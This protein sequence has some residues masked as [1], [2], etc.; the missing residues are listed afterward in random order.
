MQGKR[1]GILKKLGIKA[2]K[3]IAGRFP[4][5]RVR[6]WGLRL[7]GF[8]VGRKVYIGPGLVIAS[9][10]SEA[11]CDLIIGDRVAIGPRVILALSSDANW[12]KLNSV[13]EP[14]RGTIRL[15]ND[16]WL[17]AGVIVLPDITVGECSVAGAGS[18]V[19]SDIPPY[20]IFAGVPA[21]MIRIIDREKL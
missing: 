16:C 3:L 14:V 4:Y 12:S 6:V 15:C 7:C 8:K 1:Y 10:I 13:I 18:V 11:G 2:G 20:S 21:K 17:G 19:T 5:N 9:L